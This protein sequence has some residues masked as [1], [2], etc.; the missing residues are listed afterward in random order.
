MKDALDP[1]QEFLKST[2]YWAMMEKIKQMGRIID[3]YEKEIYTLRQRVHHANKRVHELEE[4]I[5]T[6]RKGEGKYA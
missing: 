2:H 5:E 4:R 1:T 3:T 6:I